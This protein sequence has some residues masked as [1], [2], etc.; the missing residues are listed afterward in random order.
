[1]YLLKNLV[2]PCEDTVPY[3]GVPYRTVLYGSMSTTVPYDR[4]AK[5]GHPVNMQHNSFTFAWNLT[6]KMDKIIFV[7]LYYVVNK[8]GDVILSENHDV[9]LG[10]EGLERVPGK[11]GLRLEDLICFPT[12]E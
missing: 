9:F 2:G 8:N 6:C 12:K 5:A 4:T 1:M 7:L 10:P 3:C 11:L